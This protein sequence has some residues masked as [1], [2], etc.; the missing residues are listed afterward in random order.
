MSYEIFDLEYDCV[1]RIFETN[2]KIK[3]RFYCKV[4]NNYELEL[5]SML[6]VFSEDEYEN[7]KK[8]IINLTI[9]DEFQGYTITS[10]ERSVCE[11]RLDLKRFFR[12]EKINS[13]RWDYYGSPKI[14]KLVIPDTVTE[15]KR[16]TFMSS[17]VEKVIW[18]ASLT[19]IPENCFYDSKNLK[20]IEITSPVIEI[21]EMALG[22]TAIKHL[23][24]SN[25]INVEIV[26]PSGLE[27]TEII[28]PFYA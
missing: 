3:V 10:I 26:E 11:P 2:E 23:N 21:R 27:D 9:P 19:V 15:I 12:Y 20:E 24:L 6:P 17:S 28:L 8:I 13:F 1:D 5:L 25:C 14:E 22:L 4:K 18:P 7:N 16:N